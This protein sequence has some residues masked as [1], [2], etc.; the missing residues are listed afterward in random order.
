MARFTTLSALLFAVGLLVEWNSPNSLFGILQFAG[1]VGLVVSA[2]YYG[3]R[4]FRWL[5]SKLLWKV[6]NKLIISFSFVGLIPV[7]VL[8]TIAWISIN[9]IFRQL[10]V[11]FL[12]N[13]FDFYARTLHDATERIVLRY[14]Q[15]DRRGEARLKDLIQQE[16]ASLPEVD[17]GFAATRFVLLRKSVT[18]DQ[19]SYRVV[20]GFPEKNPLA[21]PPVVPSWARDGFHGMVSEFGSLRF[22]S[23]LPV[24]EHN[25]QYLVYLDLPLDEGLSNSIRE[26]TSI[27]L[28]MFNMSQ[29]EMESAVSDMFRTG[30]GFLD[31]RWAHVLSPVAWVDQVNATHVSHGAVIEV[32]MRRLFKHFFTQSQGFGDFVIKVI[33]VLVGVFLVSELAALVIGVA[34]ARSITLSIHNI[35][36]GTRSIQTGNFDFRIPSKN[37]D[38]L[39]AMATAFNRMAES[40][41]QLMSQVSDKERLEKEVEIAREVQ[42]HLFPRELPVVRRLQLAGTCLP[43]RHVSGDYYDFIPYGESSLDVVVADISGKGISAALLMANLQSSIRSHILYES[44]RVDCEKP[45][46]RAVG[47]INRQLYMHTAPEKFAT[48]VLCRIDPNALR[49]T[50]CNAGHNP[51]LI[52]SNGSIRRLNVGGLVAGLFEFPEYDEET[53]Q[54]RDGDL[55]VFYTDGVVEAE[56]PAG[57]QFEEDRLERLI[58]DNAFLTA[59]DIRSLVVNE[60]IAWAAGREQRDDITVVTLKVDC[61]GE[62]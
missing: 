50:Y 24:R 14:Y 37:R 43:A 12:E 6:R 3:H 29:R 47:T 7:V 61:G 13:E 45:I 38:Q 15:S 2:A 48:M 1:L 27:D 36:A 46:A 17:K 31:I 60:V 62:E 58:R 9:L 49:M 52:V 10:S 51:P 22:K 35:Y 30:G 26:R 54:L 59:E 4:G 32:P 33:L 40:V 25:E 42:T 41:L 28:R 8:G 55:L 44:S 39:D 16:Q 57:E 21:D 11:V 20:G 56:N 23:L 34:I 18:R 5:K 19:V 53:I